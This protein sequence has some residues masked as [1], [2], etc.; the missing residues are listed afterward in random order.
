MYKYCR[1]VMWSAEDNASTSTLYECV[2][3][4]K[5][6]ENEK[7]HIM[8]RE[9]EHGKKNTIVSKNKIAGESKM[10]LQ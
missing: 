7:S 6:F 10:K 1:D 4:T 9:V 5:V 8:I 3:F 2:D